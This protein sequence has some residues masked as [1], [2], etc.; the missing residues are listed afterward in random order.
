MA[1]G[2]IGIV[3]L[4]HRNYYFYGLHSKMVHMKAIFVHRFWSLKDLNVVKWI[5]LRFNDLF[6]P[7]ISIV[8]NIKKRPAIQYKRVKRPGLMP[9]YFT[10]SLVFN[11][12]KL[13]CKKLFLGWKIQNQMKTNWWLAHLT[14]NLFLKC[15]ILFFKE[16]NFIYV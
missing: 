11:V 14:K 2:F 13:N 5:F 6:G 8:V 1:V 7:F 12:F 4:H 3:S 16:I 9:L 10:L 15:K